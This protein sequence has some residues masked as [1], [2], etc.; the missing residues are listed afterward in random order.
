VSSLVTSLEFSFV[1][2][3]LNS[4]S[5]FFSPESSSETVLS[6]CL[7]KRLPREVEARLAYFFYNDDLFPPVSRPDA[8]TGRSGLVCR[9]E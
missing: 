9:V 5:F 7:N 2:M 1:G 3:F 6:K 8:V 4:C